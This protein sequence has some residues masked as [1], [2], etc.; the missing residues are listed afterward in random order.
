MTS[1]IFEGNGQI[2]E[3]VGGYHDAQQQRA[4]SRTSRTVNNITVDKSSVQQTVKQTPNHTKLKKLSYKLQLELE[5]LPKRLEDLEQIIEQFQSQV[6][7]PEFFSKP[8]ETTQEVLDK[9]SAVEQELEIAFE[10]WEEL[11]ALQQD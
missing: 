7:D 9:L 1:W 6:N 10:R 4:Q 5:G 11:E 8:I 3:F 2:E